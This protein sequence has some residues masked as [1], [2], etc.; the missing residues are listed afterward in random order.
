MLLII[1]CLLCTA[2]RLK[3]N[4]MSGPFPSSITNLPK[5][6]TLSLEG[7]SFTGTVTCNA[8]TII[9]V[10]K[11]DDLDCVGDCCNEVK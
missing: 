5:L 6:K 3:G 2:L 4:S 11:D 10:G 1:I 7:N 8:L 9:T